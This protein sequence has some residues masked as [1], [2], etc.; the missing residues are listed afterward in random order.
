MPDRPRP[1][2]VEVVLHCEAVD[3]LNHEVGH[4]VGVPDG[5]DGDDGAVGDG[6]GSWLRVFEPVV[7]GSGPRGRVFVRFFSI[8][9]FL[10]AVP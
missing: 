2:A 1:G 7:H 8:K 6:T 5:R 4:R 9:A 10:V 3:E